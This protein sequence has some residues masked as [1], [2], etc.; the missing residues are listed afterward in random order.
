MAS[1]VR[2]T[3]VSMSPWTRTAPT[4]GAARGRIEGGGG[5]DRFNPDGP[6]AERPV[7]AP[8]CLLPDARKIPDGSASVN[9]S[10]GRSR[11][12]GRAASSAAGRGLEQE[13]DVPGGV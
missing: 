2:S 8:T 10:A 12:P 11:A 13:I 5:G 6:P 1:G 9:E 4:A 3:W 7:K